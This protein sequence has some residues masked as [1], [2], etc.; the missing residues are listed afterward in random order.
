VSTGTRPTGVASVATHGEHRVDVQDFRQGRSSRKEHRKFSGADIHLKPDAVPGGKAVGHLNITQAR[1]LW[2][3]FEPCTV[4][5]LPPCMFSDYLY[6]PGFRAT[7]SRFPHLRIT[8][9]ASQLP[10][11]QERRDQKQRLA[12]AG[13][14]LS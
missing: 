14:A 12:K 5:R 9:S 2:A 4:C 6:F 10:Q 3:K 1:K 11:T 7:F 8:F 13:E